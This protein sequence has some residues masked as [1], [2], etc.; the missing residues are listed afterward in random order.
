MCP[1]ARAVQGA[2]PPV[3]LLGPGPDDG[4]GV[5]PAVGVGGVVGCQGS[6]A[7]ARA[8]SVQWA[9][10]GLTTRIDTTGRGRGRPPGLLQSLRPV[11]ATAGTARQR[12]S[13]WRSADAGLQEST[14]R[15]VPRSGAR[16]AF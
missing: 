15:T 16:V 2:R 14:Y 13:R 1:A 11:E 3:A 5:E 7:Q 8:A 9:A 12:R 4:D 10:S 6:F